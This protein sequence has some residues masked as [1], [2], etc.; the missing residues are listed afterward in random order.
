MN[1]NAAEKIM[2]AINRVSHRDTSAIA[3]R[4]AN[5]LASRI[6]R[7][8]PGR[9][10]CPVQGPGPAGLRTRNAAGAASDAPPAT[11]SPAPD[12][13]QLLGLFKTKSG[14]DLSE[15][16]TQLLW[17]AREK[18]RVNFGMVREVF[19]A[20]KLTSTDLEEVYRALKE[21]GVTFGGGL[22]SV[23]SFMG[24]PGEVKALGDSGQNRI[25][26]ACES[27]L[28]LRQMEDGDL[29]LR[30]IL[31]GFGFTAH[32]H[33]TRAEKLLAHPSARNIN[34]L[35]E[36]SEIPSVTQYLQK[37]PLLVAQ[38]RKLD[39]L[40]A[41]A[42]RRWRE[43]I[44]ESSS[45]GHWIAL[46]RLDGRLQQALP[47]FH[48]QAKVIEEMVA[49][50]QGIAARFRAGRQVLEQARQCRDSVYQMPLADVESQTIAAMEEHVRVP[51]AAFLQR[52]AELKVAEV[53]FQ[54]AKSELIRGH[55]HLVVSIAGIY[56]NKGLSGSNLI[57]AG[58]AGLQRAVEQFG[59]RREWKFSAYAAC[60]IRQAV[61]EALTAQPDHV[62]RPRP[63]Q[64]AKVVE[65]PATQTSL[66]GPQPPSEA[67]PERHN[68]EL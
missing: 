41:A 31:Y 49:Y 14:L 8:V 12:A 4:K 52:C 60:W 27:Q 45:A 48:Y 46:R 28:L 10:S 26:R 55:L 3:R 17:L 68:Y 33:L 50:A 24:A 61:R 22:V 62:T 29:A 34:E 16:L 63:P 40:A 59:Y 15:G 19:S 51:C 32:E 6:C 64:F 7:K 1:V 21:A 35:I 47:K 5:R 43:T 54:R 65:T 57:R 18:G 53:E 42:S 25:L 20:D 36:A 11:A 66:P 9:C 58:I 44:D 23:E 67:H 39:H 13:P 30:R 38:V 56:A 37:L 2:N